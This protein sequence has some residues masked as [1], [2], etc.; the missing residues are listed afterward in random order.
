ML[1]MKLCCGLP[2]YAAAPDSMLQTVRDLQRPSRQGKHM[3]S[4]MSK[5]MSKSRANLHNG[6]SN[7]CHGHA[8]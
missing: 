5:Q 6:V 8:A 7:L 4:V 3:A 1:S 2:L